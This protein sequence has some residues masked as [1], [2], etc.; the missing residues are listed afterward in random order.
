MPRQILEDSKDSTDTIAMSIEIFAK[1]C[2]YFRERQGR[3]QAEMARK[4][5]VPPGQKKVSRGQ[6]AAWE[7]ARC[8]CPAA[9]LP[10]LCEAFNYYD[11]IALLTVDVSKHKDGYR[12]HE[13]SAALQKI[14]RIKTI[15]GTE[16]I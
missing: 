16:I 11:A 12:H 5:R 8:Y 13:L 6:Y 4:I 14:E 3:S 1:N 9:L 7:E 2:K 15:L 10:F